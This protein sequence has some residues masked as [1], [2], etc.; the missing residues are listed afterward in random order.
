MTL[1]PVTQ[2]SLPEAACWHWVGVAKGLAF[3]SNQLSITA[4]PINH[5]GE[6]DASI[7]H[8]FQLWVEE[9]SKEV[10]VSFNLPATTH[11]IKALPQVRQGENNEALITFS[12]DSP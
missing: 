8:P 12:S 7:S 11:R 10:G 1:S 4:Y 3:L 9:Y 6:Q 2:L 5:Q